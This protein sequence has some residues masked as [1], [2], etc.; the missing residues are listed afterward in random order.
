MKGYVNKTIMCSCGF[1][2]LNNGLL[3]GI[4]HAKEHSD[5]EIFIVE[6]PE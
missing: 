2:L 4:K 1:D 3:E 5:H 6:V